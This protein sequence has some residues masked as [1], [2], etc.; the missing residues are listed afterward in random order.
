MKKILSFF[1][2]F[3]V[4]AFIVQSCGR[5]GDTPAVP[6]DETKDRGHEMPNKIELIMTDLSTNQQHKK[7]GVLTPNGVVY[8]DETPLHLFGKRVE[9][10]ILK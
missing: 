7:V 2:T 1:M 10:I 9:N 8:D 4:L 5:D 6:T 3:L